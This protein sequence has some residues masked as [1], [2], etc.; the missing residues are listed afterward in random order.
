MKTAWTKIENWLTEHFPSM[1]ETLNEGATQQDF[2]KLQ[3]ILGKILPTDVIEFYSIHNGQTFTHLCLFN[4][5]RLL[6][7]EEIIKEW[8]TWSSVLPTINAN[9]IEIF[10]I[11]VG[12]S[13]EV[14]IK[15]DWWNP[16]WIPITS[17][18]T[19]DNYCMD[20]DPTK[21]GSSGQIIRMT[22]DMPE[23]ELIANSLRKWIDNYVNDLING[24]YEISIDIGYGGIVRK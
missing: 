21:E 1:L 23:R 5:D 20:L 10:G 14:G 19:G 2:D 9:L 24:A 15:D 13:P 22:H 12:S 16:C 7:I 17:D 11:P 4:G 3:T 8:E 6:S 18:G